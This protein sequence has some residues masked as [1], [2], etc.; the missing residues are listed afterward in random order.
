MGTKIDKYLIYSL[1]NSIW[2]NC[3][4]PLLLLS[5]FFFLS[6][7]FLARESFLLSF[8]SNLRTIS[9]YPLSIFFISP[10]GKSRT[11]THVHKNPNP[12][13]GRK[14]KEGGEKAGTKTGAKAVQDA[15]EGGKET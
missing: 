14:Q 12:H 10:K 8:Y 11:K 6:G 2:V 3:V 9:S 1:I 5:F 13:S 4:K 15:K 7:I